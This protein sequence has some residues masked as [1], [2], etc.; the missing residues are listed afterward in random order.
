MINREY[1]KRKRVENGY[2]QLELANELGFGRII[3]GSWEQGTKTP[4]TETVIRLCK[5][6]DMDAN[7]LLNLN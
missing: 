3:V 7:K 1:L 4:K 6:L 2:T 5:L